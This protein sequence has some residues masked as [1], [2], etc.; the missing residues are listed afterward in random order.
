MKINTAE[1]VS[2]SDVSDNY[3]YQRSLL[4]YHEAAKLVHG[5]VLEIGTGNGYG[6]DIIAPRTERFVTIDKHNK[7]SAPSGK[8][9]EL[10]PAAGGRRRATDLAPRSVDEA[11]CGGPQRT[12]TVRATVPPLPFPDRSFDTVVSFQVI[13]HVRRDRELV[14]EIYRVLRPGG[15]LIVSTPNIKMSLTRNPWHVREYTVEGFAQLLESKFSSVD[16][17]G[18]FGR[19]KVMKYY[20]NNRRSVARVARWDILGMRNWLPRWLL[21]V[22]YDILNRI[23]RRRLLADD[24]E[25]TAGITMDDYFLA[26]ATDECFDLFYTARRVR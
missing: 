3:V 21:K 17:L 18:V 25:L 12:S 8:G 15:Q 19:G 13:E 6:I 5:D 14:A 24:R 11:A 16:K 23:N 2:Q 1:R 4:A 7:G 22:P 9:D 26:P 20:G 10:S